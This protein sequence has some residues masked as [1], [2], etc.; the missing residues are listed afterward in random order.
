M[1]IDVHLLP[2]EKWVELL[3]RLI[4]CK[5][6][7]VIFKNLFDFK[8]P[9]VKVSLVNRYSLKLTSRELELL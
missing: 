6:N 4:K 5:F 2:L 9:N 7:T 8:D 3:P 1:T